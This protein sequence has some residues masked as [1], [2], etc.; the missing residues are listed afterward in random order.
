MVD[1]SE[2]SIA[3]TAAPAIAIRTGVAPSRP[4]VPSP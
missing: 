2:M 4:I 1:V 3:L